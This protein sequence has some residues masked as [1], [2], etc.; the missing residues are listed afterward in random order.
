MGNLLQFP[1]IELP[2]GDDRLIIASAVPKDFRK[3]LEKALQ[4]GKGL[5][6]AN[7]EDVRNF[8]EGMIEWASEQLGI[9]LRE[10]ERLWLAD[11]FSKCKDLL[12]AD[13]AIIELLTEAR[14]IRG[15]IERGLILQT[16]GHQG[17]LASGGFVERRKP[18]PPAYYA[19][20]AA[21]A[22]GEAALCLNHPVL[23]G[24]TYEDK[25]PLLSRL[26]QF[27][28]IL[29]TSNGP[30]PIYEFVQMNTQNQVNNCLHPL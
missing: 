24:I 7:L 6:G 3:S 22:Y 10:G 9:H 27:F 28:R 23:F 12:S 29:C 18:S 30:L 1:G 17:L 20:Q 5:Q 14:K 11:I 15:K 2:T 26:V 8:F 16:I 4:K 25:V 19:G 13:K 21:E